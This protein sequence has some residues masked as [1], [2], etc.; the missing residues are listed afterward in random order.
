MWATMFSPLNGLDSSWIE[1]NLHLVS[2]LGFRIYEDQE[3]GDIYLGIDGMGYS[4]YEAHW[5]P[6]YKA[7]GLKWHDEEIEEAI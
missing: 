4:F 1:E 5:I 6:L 7:R 3:T 2:S